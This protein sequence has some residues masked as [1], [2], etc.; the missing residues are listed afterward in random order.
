[1]R[2]K[3]V[4]EPMLNIS[5]RRISSFIQYIPQTPDDVSEFGS[6]L[7]KPKFFS[8]QK[9]NLLYFLESIDIGVKKKNKGL[10]IFE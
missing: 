8:F 5:P 6:F 1:M 3:K 7:R 10:Q 4:D 2:T 9:I